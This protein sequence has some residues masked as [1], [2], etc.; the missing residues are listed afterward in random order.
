MKVSNSIII[1]LILFVLS[2]CTTNYWVI[3]DYEREVDFNMYKTYEVYNHANGFPKGANPINKQRIERAIKKEMIEL[4]YEAS[5]EPDLLVSWYVTV[6]DKRVMDVYRDFYHRWAYYAV[7][8]YEYQEGTLVIDMIDRKKNE[9][10]WHGKTS[11]RV[12]EG[13][14]N[15]DKK[16]K[17]AVQS[18]LEKYAKDVKLNKVYASK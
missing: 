9:V 11:E 17:K 13:M 3:S 4:G 14:P 8:V 6:E 18:M 2:G 15:V 7:N 10:V 12:Y 1:V 16:I 5:E